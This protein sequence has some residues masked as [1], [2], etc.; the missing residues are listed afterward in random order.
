MR[1]LTVVMM[2]DAGR[3][4][5]LAERSYQLTRAYPRVGRPDVV[6]ELLTLDLDL[7]PAGPRVGALAPATLTALPCRNRRFYVPGGLAR[8]ERRVAA[9]DVVH[10]VGHWTPITTLAYQA[11]RRHA[12]PWVVSPCGSLPVRGR[13]R[14]LKH[15]YNAAVGGRLIRDAAAAVAVTDAERADF[16]PYGRDPAGVRVIPN[17]VS[18]ADHAQDAGGALV[19]RLGLGGRRYLLFLGRLNHIKGVDLLVEA[20]A[21]SGAAEAGWALVLAGPDEGLGSELRARA[22]AAGVGDVVRFAGVV[23]GSE[24]TEALR[25]AALLVVPSRHEAMSIVALEA[26]VNG[27]PVLLTRSC[28][29]DAVERAGGGLVVDASVRALTGGLRVLLAR[30]DSLPARGAALRRLVLAEFTWER[31]ASRHLA[32]FDEVL[33]EAAGHGQRRSDQVEDSAGRVAAGER[34]GETNRCG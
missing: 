4:G 14:V 34:R 27:T 16:A 7:D 21:A 8:I 26:G 23:T 15:G 9:A 31:A 33:D 13:S 25:E 22:A 12:V 18:P 5:G 19:R 20:F 2:A 24:R 30:P 29:F 17:G 6:A 3:G 11:A 1:V 10:L 32:V 28:G